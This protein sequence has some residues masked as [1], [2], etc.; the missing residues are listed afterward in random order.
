MGFLDWIKGQ[1]ATPNQKYTLER[2]NAVAPVTDNSP[3]QAGRD[4]FRI[5]LAEMHLQHGSNWFE[6]RYP[7]VYSSVQLQFAAQTQHIDTL[8]GPSRLKEVDKEHLERAI[9][10]NYQLTPLLPFNGGSV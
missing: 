9:G 7:V 5:W 6:T 3:V 2:D 1:T 4:Y 10:L 8:A